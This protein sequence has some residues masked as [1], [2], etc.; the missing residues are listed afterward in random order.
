[1]VYPR[2]V[3]LSAVL[4][5]V[6]ECGTDGPTRWRSV[7]GRALGPI[8]RVPPHAVRWEAVAASS[9]EAGAAAF[10]RT[11]LGGGYWSARRG[12]P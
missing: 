2:V 5:R 6:A 9:G 8:A 7:R 4:G 10:P 1:M 3:E 12:L 11:A